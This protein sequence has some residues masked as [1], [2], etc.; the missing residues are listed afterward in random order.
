MTFFYNAIALGFSQGFC[1]AMQVSDTCRG[2]QTIAYIS[3]YSCP[4]VEKLLPAVN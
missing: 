1:K 3:D 2:T 4:F